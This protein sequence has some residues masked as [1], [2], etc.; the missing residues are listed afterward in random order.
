MSNVNSPV[1]FWIGMIVLVA[2]SIMMIVNPD[3]VDGAEIE[4]RQTILKVLVAKVW[5][6]PAGVIGLLL[7]GAAI[8]GKLKKKP[9]REE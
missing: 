4:G 8:Y 3:M 1:R 7:A 9:D 2:V 5:S 6:I